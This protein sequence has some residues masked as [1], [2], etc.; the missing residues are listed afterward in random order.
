MLSSAKP[1][2]KHLLDQLY[3]IVI[4]FKWITPNK[5]L[6][7]V[8][9]SDLKSTPSFEDQPLSDSTLFV[10]SEPIKT[11]AELYKFI[12]NFE[13]ITITVDEFKSILTIEPPQKDYIMFCYK[14]FRFP[15]PKLLDFLQRMG[16]SGSGCI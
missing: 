14:K 11:F 6:I 16:Y 13:D 7:N 9:F 10:K 1:T 2:I 5:H 4:K 8:S 12:D 15:F 3:K